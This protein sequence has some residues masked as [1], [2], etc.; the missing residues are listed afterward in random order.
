[1]ITAW[2]DKWKLLPAYLR[3]R[4]LVRQHIDSYDHFLNVDIRNIMLANSVVRCEADSKWFLRYRDIR[5]GLPQFDEED[6]SRT[7]LTPHECRLRDITYS[8][9]IEV[10]VEVS[11]MYSSSSLPCT[12]HHTLAHALSCTDGASGP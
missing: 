11:V 2:Q 8:A 6:Q 10:L 4:G 3:V 12:I 1:M 9:P 5:V 7:D